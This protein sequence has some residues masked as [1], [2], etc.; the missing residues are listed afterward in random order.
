[1]NRTQKSLWTEI[2]YRIGHKPPYNFIS[3][4]TGQ[5]TGIFHW[6]F[7]LPGLPHQSGLIYFGGDLGPKPLFETKAALW[8]KYHIKLHQNVT[9]TTECLILS[10]QMLYWT[11]LPIGALLQ[12]GFQGLWKICWWQT[13]NFCLGPPQRHGLVNSM[14]KCHY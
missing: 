10:V 3:F 4:K 8:D 2:K 7:L 13:G 1:M 6:I 11:P 5:R 9:S 12:F 14:A